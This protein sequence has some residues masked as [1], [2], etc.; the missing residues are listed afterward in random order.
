MENGRAVTP[1]LTRANCVR[2]TGEGATAGG[3]EATASD[4]KS[5][6]HA[7]NNVGPSPTLPIIQRKDND[8]R[9][10][11]TKFTTVKD[12]KEFIKDLSDDLEIDVECT[13][14][15]GFVEN[16]ELEKTMF[17]NGEAM[18]SVNIKAESGFH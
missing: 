10:V 9:Q 7:V 16:V 15:T 2:F 6:T 17:D 11:K 8:M 1:S 14:S 13:G 12:L 5:D 3:T 18:L 4:C